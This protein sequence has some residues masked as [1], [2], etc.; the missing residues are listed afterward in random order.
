[1]EPVGAATAWPTLDP[2]VAVTLLLREAEQLA[3]DASR[4]S[5]VDESLL[6]D[7]SPLGR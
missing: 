2:D 3:L 1:M 4:H 5:P 7:L 6:R